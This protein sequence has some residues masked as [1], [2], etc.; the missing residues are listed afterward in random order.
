MLEM[1]EKWGY[2][3]A[4]IPICLEIHIYTSCKSSRIMSMYNVLGTI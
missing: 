4:V 1:N 3:L 2:V